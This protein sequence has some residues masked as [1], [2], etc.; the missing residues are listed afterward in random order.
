MSATREN[1]SGPSSSP[2]ETGHG[3]VRSVPRGDMLVVLQLGGRQVPG[4]APPEHR[5]CLSNVNA[6]RLGRSSSRNGKIAGTK[7]EPFA[8]E[9]RE[10][11]RKLTIGAPVTYTVNYKNPKNDT[12][13]AT[14]MMDGENVANKIAEAGWATIREASGKRETDPEHQELLTLSRQAQEAKRGIFTDDEKK[15]KAAIRSDPPAADSF[16]L[17]ER[18]RKQQKPFELLVEHVR[19]GSTVRGVLK[20]GLESVVVRL[21]GVQAPQI[22]YDP[23]TKK[24]SRPEPFYPEAMFFAEQGVLNRD[25]ELTVTSVDAT[26]NSLVGTISV[27]GRDLGEE[28]L[29]AGLACV[30]D[31][32]A[33]SAEKLKVYRAAEAAAQAARLRMWRGFTPKV[34]DPSVL[35]DDEVLGRVREIKNGGKLVLSI[36][37][38]AQ[39]VAKEIDLSS[40]TVPRLNPRDGDDE[41]FAWEA[42]QF[43]RKRLIGKK[44]RAQLDYSR[45]LKKREGETSPVIREFWSIYLD[46]TNIA[47]M[48]IERGFAKVV[49]HRE[50]EPRSPIYAQLVLAEEKCRKTGRGM[51]GS[52]AAAHHINDL[53]RPS[54]GGQAA[55]AKSTKNAKGFLP[56]L[57]RSGRQAAVV[58]HVY[59]GARFK[60]YCPNDTCMLN[61]ALSTIR[62]PNSRRDGPAVPFA[63]ES[64]EFSRNLIM[65]RDVQVE[66]ENI[67]RTG[68]FVGRVF[69]N[70]QDLALTLLEKGLASVHEP[71]AR[72]SDYGEEYLKIQATAREAR[73]GMW[74]NYQEPKVVERST[75][76]DADKKEKKQQWFAVQVTEIIDAGHFYLQRE[77]DDVK[78]LQRS[79]NEKDWG[80]PVAGFDPKVGDIVASQFAEDKDWYR[81]SVTKVYPGKNGIKEYALRYIDYGNTD[82]VDPRTLRP[83]PVEFTVA[84]IPAQAVLSTL[85]FVK[86]PELTAEFGEDAA[87]MLRDLV[88]GKTM[89]ANIESRNNGEVQVSLGDPGTNVLV[90]SALV[91]AGLARP[92]KR[93]EKYLESIM[94]KLNQHAEKA[95][96][97]RRGMWRYGD[98]PDD[99][100][101]E[102]DFRK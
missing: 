11:L 50:G 57:L 54:K 91:E 92:E 81:A 76:V 41:P 70:G 55:A 31:W 15:R 19:N 13:F 22:P 2:K 45:E 58:E 100:E 27:G 9:S 68:T 29:K 48:L 93:R 62:C 74:L 44:V 86:V 4:G 47:L 101:D 69:F 80:V 87:Y 33:P 14:V 89:M 32:N 90:A 43:L 23:E 56:F 71:S 84:R 1:Q 24:E 40:V 3:I 16:A 88:W 77:C 61:I 38:G 53:T 35:A 12:K 39:A 20:P 94:R 99:E 60:V 95:R 52:K 64:T 65:Q 73:V 5:L 72:H 18:C 102:P 26:S 46:R 10:F 25:V 30:V 82:V 8:W 7:D 37:Q 83:L 67:D 96:A 66:V 28:L 17:Y 85:A 6:P 59:S 78:E 49:R 51:F 42:K 36:G 21:A 97:A 79:L 75:D 98:I 63:E 34:V